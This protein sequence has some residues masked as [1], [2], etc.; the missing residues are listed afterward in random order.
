MRQEGNE[1]GRALL[2]HKPLLPNLR[3]VLLYLG[4][5]LQLGNWHV[6]A[7][8]DKYEKQSCSTSLLS[9]SFSSMWG[10]R[11]VRIQG[12]NEH[13]KGG[14]EDW[15]LLRGTDQ[16][17]T[18]SSGLSEAG[19]PYMTMGGNVG[20]PAPSVLGSPRAAWGRLGTVS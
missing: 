18:M 8:N 19:L 6:H 2:V 12:A 17:L 16:R 1:T 14:N 10:L 15:I 5:I 13:V 4:H 7:N 20:I 9:A 3:S 11:T